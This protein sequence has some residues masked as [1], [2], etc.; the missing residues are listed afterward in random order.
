VISDHFLIGALGV[1]QS[2]VGVFLVYA[3]P[4]SN[5]HLLQDNVFANNQ[6]NVQRI[7]SAAAF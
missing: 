3:K 5:P 2:S 4:S 1:P 6:V 7:A